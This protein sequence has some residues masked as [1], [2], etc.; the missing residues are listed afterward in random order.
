MKKHFAVVTGA[1]S[2]IGKEFARQLA[3]EGYPLVLV[4]RRKERLEELKAELE[5]KG[6]TCL[7]I[8]AD[9]SKTAECIRLVEE[10]EEIP[11]SIFINN[12][13]FGDCGSF[14]DTDAKKELEM[15][16]VNIKAMHLL[17]KKMLYSM[18]Q[19]GHG[20][21]LNVASSAGL[22]PAGPYMATYYATK[23]YVAS[24]T[25]AVAAELKQKNSNVYV[26]A[27][28]PG[29]V[30]TE[31]NDVANVEF[32]LPGITPEYCASYAISQMKRRKTVIVPTLTLKAA[33][34][35]AR[36][37]P[38]KLLIDIVGHQQKKKLTK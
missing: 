30:D 21:L 38:Q 35:F 28:C 25:R 22:L 31:F 17:M 3:R 19:Q 23:A 5:K 2:G 12:A 32:A 29:P 37:I 4:A 13:G 20:Y 7:L 14:L 27:L 1:S 8:T 11:V 6:T 9:L 34:T 10:L 18:E 26:G 16:D 15:I 24:L 33:T 36:F